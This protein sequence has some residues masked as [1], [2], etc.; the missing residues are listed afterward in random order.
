MTSG[1]RS[2]WKKARKPLEALGISIVCMLVLTLLVVIVLTYVFKV[3][4]AGLRGKTLWDWLQLLIIPAVLAVGGYLFNY[5]TSRNERAATEQRAQTERD[6]AQDNQQEATLQDYINKMS[7]LLLDRDL[8]KS[9]VKDEVQK[10]ARVRTLTILPRLNGKR[11]GIVL[12]FLYE[13]QLINKGG[14]IVDLSGA[15]LM[16]ADL[17]FTTLTGA[18]LSG[19]NF[20]WARFFAANLKGADLSHAAL[21]NANLSH[22]NLSGADL[23][24]AGLMGA[25]LKGADLSGAI[26]NETY[27]RDAILIDA[28]LSRTEVT[29]EQL[30]KARSLEGAIMPDGSKHA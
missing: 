2:W 28:N 26:L 7:E 22:T 23:S 18:D 11:K 29:E 3:D 4:V 12:Q 9:T 8:C 30:N 25:N 6:I 21:I 16:G 14:R 5:T 1:L 10:I 13:A 24:E 15:D 27:L 20:W 17:S 19:A